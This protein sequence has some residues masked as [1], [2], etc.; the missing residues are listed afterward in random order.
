MPLS[1]LV[2]L[3]W[4]STAIVES[5]VDY[6]DDDR[7]QSGGRVLAQEY[8]PGSRT[9]RGA[10]GVVVVV[11]VG[12]GGE[13]QGENDERKTGATLVGRDFA[14][15]RYEFCGVAGFGRGGV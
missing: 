10:A 5:A 7:K 14:Y 2:E 13:E 6:G 12:G 1:E 9:Q 15:L 11:V 8:I 4:V 3:E